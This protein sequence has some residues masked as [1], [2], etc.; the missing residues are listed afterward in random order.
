MIFT[1]AWRKR[2]LMYVLA[3]CCYSKKGVLKACSQCLQH[4]R[5]F[6]QLNHTNPHVHAP[7]LSLP[8]E[9]QSVCLKPA[10]V[11]QSFLLSMRVPFTL[12]E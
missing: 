11:T 6:Q 9:T 2:V 8:Q 5:N 7:R 10:A 12:P 4:S 1:E 3:V